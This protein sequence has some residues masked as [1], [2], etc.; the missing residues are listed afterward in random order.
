MDMYV[1]RIAENPKGR[2]M[3]VS[4]KIIGL[5]MVIGLTSGTVHAQHYEYKEH[6][7]GPTGLFGITSPTNIKITTKSDVTLAHAILK[8]RPLAK[9][10]KRLGAFEEAQW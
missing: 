2:P 8:A 4:R 6:H 1:D 9:P 3:S 7:L 5:L 10:A